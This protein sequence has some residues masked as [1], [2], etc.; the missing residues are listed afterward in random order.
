MLPYTKENSPSKFELF[1]VFSVL[2][3]A[4]IC[5]M[6][7]ANCRFDNKSV[8]AVNDKLVLAGKRNVCFCLIPSNSMSSP[9]ALTYPNKSKSTL[10]QELE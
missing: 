8:Y 5:I 9:L 4:R 1:C 6:C 10:Y 7:R 2:G 3:M